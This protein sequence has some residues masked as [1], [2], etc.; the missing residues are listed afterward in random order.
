MENK[1]C[2]ILTTCE[3]RINAVKIAKHLIKNK[4]CACVNIIDSIQSFY[5]WEDKLQESGEF[6][7]IIKTQKILFEK[8]KNAI[9]S[10]HE[11]KIPEIISLDIEKGHQDYLNWVLNNT[12]IS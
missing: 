4:L 7:L 9:L 10:I 3:T 11:Y 12:Q 2:T 6:L 1:F 8:V 5:M